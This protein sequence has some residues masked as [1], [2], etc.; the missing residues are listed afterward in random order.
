MHE[1]TDLSKT[2]ALLTDLLIGFAV[3][4]ALGV[5]FEF[6]EADE[7]NFKYSDEMVGEGTYN[8]PAGTF[9][10]DTSML[11]CTVEALIND[12]SLKGIADN[13]LKWK[14]ENYWTARGEVFDCGNTIQVALK[15][16][17]KTGDLTGLST[18]NQYSCGNGSLMRI[19]PLL[20]YTIKLN[21]DEKFE[22]IKQVSA[23]THGHIRTAIACFIYLEFAEIVY[24]DRTVS[25]RI[26]FSRLLQKVVPFLMAKQELKEEMVHFEKIL[27]GPNSIPVQEFS[28]SGYVID[29]LHL[30]LHCFMKYNRYE[31]CVWYAI[32]FGGDTDTNAAL[33]GALCTLMGGKREIPERWLSKLAK[34]DELFDLAERWAM[35]LTK[36]TIQ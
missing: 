22:L 23:I 33:T 5:P 16:Y 32:S 8:Q 19:L 31:M 10:D 7:I 24:M 4:D 20:P 34:K 2:T 28:N 3:G 6:L 15:A 17:E 30:C 13:F 27:D 25:K 35:A 29:S 26:I 9:S 1:K 21:Q 18:N 12:N 11:C 14:N 36:T